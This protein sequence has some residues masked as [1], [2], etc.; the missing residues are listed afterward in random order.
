LPPLKD[1]IAVVIS[2]IAL[3]VSLWSARRGWRFNLASL[4]K[5]TR[6]YYM[7]AL[8]DINRQLIANPQLWAVYGTIVAPTQSTAAGQEQEAGRRLAFIWYHL[9]LYEMVYAEFQLNRLTTL[10]YD[11]RKFWES[12]D[13]YVRSFLSNSAEARAVVANDDSMKLLNRDFVE[14]LRG[15]L[16]G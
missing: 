3:V 8:F 10:D 7:T 1:F 14:Y 6:N 9:N 13:R 11:D 2:A 15:C 4:R 16:R 5:A 12:W